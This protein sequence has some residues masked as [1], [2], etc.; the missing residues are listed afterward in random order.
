MSNKKLA[1][2]FPS[3]L[4]KLREKGAQRP[5]LIISF[6]PQLVGE[7]LAPLTRAEMFE[8]GVLTVRVGNSS[9]LSLLVQYEQMR[10]LSELKRQFPS[11]RIRQIRFRIGAI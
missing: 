3:F 5:D 2:L 1:G 9:L 10:L 7:K 8:A 4:R 11:A 6:W